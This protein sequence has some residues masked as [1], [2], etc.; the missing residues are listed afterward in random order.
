VLCARKGVALR[1]PILSVRLLL[2]SISWRL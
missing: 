2:R 1:V